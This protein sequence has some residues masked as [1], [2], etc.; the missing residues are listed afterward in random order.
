MA[1]L[2]TFTSGSVLTAAELNT[3][4]PACV[5]SA[6]AVSCPNTTVVQVTFSTEDYDPLGWHSTV[7]NT[8]RITPN[9]AG[10]FLVTAQYGQM[11]GAGANFR[12]LMSVDK[13]ASNADHA[14]FDIN[15][16]APDDA[17]VAGL[18]YLNGTTDYVVV[19]LYQASGGTKTPDVRF[20][21]V[22][23]AR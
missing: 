5:L 17:S 11:N 16:Y 12:A 14:R 23:V 6:S 1:T 7:T 10:W 9:I 4:L 13:N 20:N 21:C 22:L 18:M 2:G 8:G 15:N 19:N 3:V